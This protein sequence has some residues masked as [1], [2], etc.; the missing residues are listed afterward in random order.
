MCIYDQEGEMGEV[1]RLNTKSQGK[2]ILHDTDH[3]ASGGEGSVYVKNGTAYKIYHK[4]DKMLPIAK[5]HE[6]QVLKDLKLIVIPEEILYGPNGTP[7]GYSMKYIDDCEFLCRLFTGIFRK[8]N[9]ISHSNIID[10]IKIMQNTLDNIHSRGIIVGD[11]N[12]MNFIMDKGITS[13][14]HIDVDSWQTPSFKCTAINPSVQDM[15]VTEGYFDINTDWY[16]WA[17]VTFQLY[18][19]I[20]PYKG[21]H[22]KYNASQFSERVRNRISVFDPDVEVPATGQDF[23]VIPKEHL[24]YFKQVFVKGDRGI[25]PTLGAVNSFIATVAKIVKGSDTFTV[26][27]Y[28]SI[29]NDINKIFNFKEDLYILTNV[30]YVDFQKKEQYLAQGIIGLAE[31]LNNQPVIVSKQDNVLTYKTQTGEVI[32]TSQHDK[33]FFL[34]GACYTICNDQL[35]ENTFE[36]YRKVIHTTRL[37]DTVNRNSYSVYDGLIVQDIVRKT[38][39]TIPYKIGYCATTRVPELD[40][41]RVIDAK[42]MGGTAIIM[43]E[44]AGKYDRFIINFEDSHVKYQV[45]IS[46]D[47]DLHNINFTVLPNKMTLNVFS[48]EKIEMFMHN[49]SQV[50]EVTKPPF[51]TENTLYNHLGR[52]LY[53]DGNKIM[54]CSLK[55]P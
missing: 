54:K 7:V 41:Y 38:Y 40:G 51:T 34:N 8:R 45:S 12:E 3:K 23:S 49:T 39:L 52:V 18:T 31:V 2:I 48:D 30:G 9:K 5:I 17:V 28:Y 33:G 15:S 20:H 50:K 19:G 32:G 13:P 35:I 46:S 11:Y 42:Y 24:D 4:V 27:D 21:R 25:P 47:V 55:K 44:T 1:I 29:S 43:A 36:M 53:V 10:I 37:A 14:Y 26:E 16:S 22:A 6:L